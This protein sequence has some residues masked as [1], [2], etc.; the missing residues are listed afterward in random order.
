MTDVAL[1]ARARRHS[2]LLIYVQFLIL[3][4]HGEA[5]VNDGFFSLPLSAVSHLNEQSLFFLC[6]GHCHEYFNSRWLPASLL[7]LAV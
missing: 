6:C 1:S 7:L 4:L 2:S 3:T 5:V